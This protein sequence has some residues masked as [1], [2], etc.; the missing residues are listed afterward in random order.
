MKKNIDAVAYIPSL[1]CT[2]MLTVPHNEETISDEHEFAIDLLTSVFQT[3]GDFF[4]P[5]T[6]EYRVFECEDNVSPKSIFETENKKIRS[7]TIHSKEGIDVEHLLNGIRELPEDKS[8]Q[9]LYQLTVERAATNIWLRDSDRWIDRANDELFVRWLSNGPSDTPP[10]GDPLQLD[11][12]FYPGVDDPTSPNWEIKVR[13][14]TD[15][16]FEESAV[17]K[18][19]ANRLGEF[20]RELNLVVEPTE[21]MFWSDRYDDSALEQLGISN[22]YT[23][24]S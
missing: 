19:N 9:L 2:W 13:T 21:A 6:I 8:A 3:F 24:V 10:A 7:N 16:W 12:Q 5:K 4:R 20:L 23:S 22:E 1:N 11:V 15:I 14:S 17:G 18:T